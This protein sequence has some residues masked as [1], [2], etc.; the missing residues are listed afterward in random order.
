MSDSTI[1]TA[2]EFGWA[3]DETLTGP[4]RGHDQSGH[5][6]PS[7]TLSITTAVDGR[8]PGSFVLAFPHLVDD[9]NNTERDVETLTIA[10]APTRSK[11]PP[12]PPTR[13]YDPGPPTQDN[14]RLSPL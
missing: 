5:S 2:D 14:I 9:A 13:T 4:R 6:A 12:H 11:A 10:S 8:A 7:P 1:W 3:L